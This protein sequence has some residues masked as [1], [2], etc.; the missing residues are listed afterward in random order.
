MQPCPDHRIEGGIVQIADM[1]EGEY[2]EQHGLDG[3]Y[4]PRIETRITVL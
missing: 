1:L 4:L 3:P 2:R